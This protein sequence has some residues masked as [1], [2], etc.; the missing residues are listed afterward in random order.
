LF[1]IKEK[2]KDMDLRDENID[3]N[4]QNE[5][6]LNHE[7]SVERVPE[8]EEEDGDQAFGVFSDEYLLGVFWN[9]EL[10]ELFSDMMKDVEIRIVED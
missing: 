1:L 4:H 9:R 7:F 10:A 3:K 6:T 8:F 5:E 2:G